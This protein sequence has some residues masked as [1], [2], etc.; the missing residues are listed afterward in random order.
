MWV[1]S[2][3]DIIQ[4]FIF[5]C[6]CWIILIAVIDNCNWFLLWV[7][8]M[9]LFSGLAAIFCT[10]IM[11]LLFPSY[12]L[13]I[14]SSIYCIIVFIIVCL[15]LFFAADGSVVVIFIALQLRVLCKTRN[16]SL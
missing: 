4:L 1:R 6:R 3:S 15:I 2:G 11:D 5:L 8:A 14:F 7:V 10:N 9:T 13:Y 12:I 16:L